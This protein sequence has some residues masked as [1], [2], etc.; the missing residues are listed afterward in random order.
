ME[1]S[2]NI[3]NVTTGKISLILNHASLPVWVCH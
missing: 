1:A 3:I 2:N